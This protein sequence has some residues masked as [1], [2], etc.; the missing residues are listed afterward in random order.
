[1]IIGITECYYDNPATMSRECY[2]DGKLFYSFAHSFIYGTSRFVK[3]ALE[4]T[5]L[6]YPWIDDQVRG[7]IEAL[8]PD[9][10]TPQELKWTRP[11]DKE[12]PDFPTT[13]KTIIG[14]WLSADDAP[15]IDHLTYVHGDYWNQNS[16]N[17]TTKPDYYI[18]APTIPGD[19]K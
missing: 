9:V 14:L 13:H 5:G 18:A 16:C 2:V 12:P 1:M 7:N 6:N 19:D 17:K 8:S 10:R 15:R 3:E 4:T 11:E